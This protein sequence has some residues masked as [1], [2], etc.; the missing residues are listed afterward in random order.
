MPISARGRQLLRLAHEQPGLTRAGAAAL[1]G[2]SSGAATD[3]VTA[4]AQAHLLAEEPVAQAG[5]RGRPTRRLAAHP[6]GP[7]VLA[8]VLAHE[9]WRL[10]AVELGG[11]V[12]DTSAGTHPGTDAAPVLRA[13]RT[14]GRRLERRFPGRVRGLGLAVPGL[15]QAGHLLDAP[16]L[17]WHALDLRPAAPA[18]V[19]LTAGNDATLAAVGEARRGA[20][21]GT[22]LAIHLHVD[23]GLGG[24]VTVAG[25]VLAGARGLAGEFGHMPFGDP[26][27]RCACGARGC[28]GTAVDGSAMARTLGD[29]PPRDPVAY[30]HR[31]LDR[32]GGG[33]PAAHRALRD[34]GTA[35][36]RGIAGLVTGLDPDLVTLGG[37]GTDLLHHVPGEVRAA[38]TAGLMSFRRDAPPEIAAAALGVDGPLVGAAEEVWSRVLGDPT[39]GGSPLG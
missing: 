9:S 3:L 5:R 19:E 28:W 33:D 26:A 18:G 20:A 6:Q 7:V 11:A 27:V 37:L 30:A 25:R 39:D 22:A 15:V 4:L 12:L 21:V 2:L 29:G 32:A 36:G 13:L 35:L 1:L 31:V 23:A 38:F 10:V 17:D 8:G 24:A 16:M 34:A 14:A